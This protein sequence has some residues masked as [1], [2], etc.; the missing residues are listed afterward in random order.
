MRS[1]L[2]VEADS[3]VILDLTAD[4]GDVHIN[5]IKAHAPKDLPRRLDAAPGGHTEAETPPPLFEQGDQGRERLVIPGEGVVDV[6]DE[7]VFE[8]GAHGV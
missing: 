3:P 1:P 6:T 2:L 7:E 4:G 5:A 8:Q